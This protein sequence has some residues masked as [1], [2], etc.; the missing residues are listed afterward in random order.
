MGVGAGVSVASDN[1]NDGMSIWMIVPRE[2]ESV[3]EP[4][5]SMIIEESCVS[6]TSWRVLP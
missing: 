5:R 6:A 4:Q 1:D 2:L 3:E